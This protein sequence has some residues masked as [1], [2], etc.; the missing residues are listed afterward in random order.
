MGPLELGY[1]KLPTRNTGCQMLAIHLAKAGS[2]S[3]Q[4]LAILA[5]ATAEKCEPHRPLRSGG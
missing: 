5:S 4:K 2:P 3:A 1:E